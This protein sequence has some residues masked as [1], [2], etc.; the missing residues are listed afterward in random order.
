MDVYLILAGNISTKMLR[1]VHSNKK[2]LETVLMPT[3]HQLILI[4]CCLVLNFG[5]PSTI[6]ALPF[7]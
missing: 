1:L 6:I 7:L 4:D 2:L 3:Y 5:F